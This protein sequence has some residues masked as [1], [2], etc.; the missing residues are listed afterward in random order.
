MI[1][2]SSE[3]MLVYFTVATKSGIIMVNCEKLVTYLTPNCNRV[4]WFDS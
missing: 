1:G 3:L 4:P 2:L